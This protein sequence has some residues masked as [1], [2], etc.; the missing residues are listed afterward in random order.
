MVIVKAGLDAGHQLF[1]VVAEVDDAGS[2]C[3][4]YSRGISDQLVAWSVFFLSNANSS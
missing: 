4:D 3:A 1:V 2:C